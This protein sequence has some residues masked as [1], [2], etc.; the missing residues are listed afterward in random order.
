MQWI[1]TLSI[2]FC[3]MTII[4]QLIPREKYAKYVKFYSGLIIL[5]I[6][7]DPV[8]QLFT[9]NDELT[10]YLKI[11]FLKNDYSNLEQKTES[12]AEMKTEQILRSLEKESIRQIQMLASAYG[13]KDTKVHIHYKDDYR[14]SEIELWISGQSSA[15]ELKKEIQGLFAAEAVHIHQQYISGGEY[16]EIAR[17]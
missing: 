3:I 4:T 15:A 12:L 7:L 11:E 17:K 10:N 8:L 16:E 9:E 5:L 6:A 14:V 2:S 13:F 1:K